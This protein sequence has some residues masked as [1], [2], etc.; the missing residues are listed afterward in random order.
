MAE[1]IPFIGMPMHNQF[2]H[3]GA[4]QAMWH[5][6]T[7]KLR[8]VMHGD[9]VNTL[10]PHAFNKLW[11]EALNNRKDHGVTHFA[12]IHSDVHPEPGWLDVLL[13][14]MQAH[15]ADV[16]A[17]VIPIKNPRGLTSTA[18]GLDDDNA[19]RFTMSEIMELPETFSAADTDWPDQPL[20][21][22]TGLFV[23]DIR[24]AWAEEWALNC[25]FRIESWIH[26]V[27]GVLHPG[28]ASED[29]LFSR[30]LH[31]MGQKVMATRKPPLIHRGDTGYSNQ[32]A[33]GSWQHD[34]DAAEQE[35][36]A[37]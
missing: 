17:A 34:H 5:H 27:D 11:C 29:W 26:E 13:E 25:G 10:L 31:R 18:I 1:I 19:R 14:E 2:V 16:M 23:A 6:A 4:A 15:S 28:V 37:A 36:A 22:N 30:D 20:L 33:W 21:V 12:M 32:F 7:L 3:R 9:V 35:L 24:G 8:N